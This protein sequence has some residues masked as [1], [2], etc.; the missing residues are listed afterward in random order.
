[1]GDKEQLLCLGGRHRVWGPPF[2]LSLEGPGV[3]HTKE[4]KNIGSQA[5]P[6]E[7]SVQGQDFLI[8]ENFNL[9]LKLST[10]KPAKR[11][12]QRKFPINYI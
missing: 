4:E 7:M 5:K 1:M 6:L 3:A 11:K 2:L 9:S 12:F 8:A 10:V